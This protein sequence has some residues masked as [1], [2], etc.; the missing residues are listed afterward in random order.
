MTK[1]I[2][3]GPALAGVQAPAGNEHQHICVLATPLFL[4]PS[5][6]LCSP[7]LPGTGASPQ[8]D[9]YGR[10]SREDRKR[11]MVTRKVRGRAGGEASSA[12]DLQAHRQGPQKTAARAADSPGPRGLIISSNAGFPGNT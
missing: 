1:R 8:G 2:C 7:K 10:G 11:R 12:A 6:R 9:R 5:L 3:L 4:D